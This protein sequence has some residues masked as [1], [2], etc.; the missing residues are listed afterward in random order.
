[1][2]IS[3]EKVFEEMDALL[4][5]FGT[6]VV[7]GGAVRDYL[8]SRTPKDYDI[9]ILNTA[10]IET[11]SSVKEKVKIATRDI[12]K[13]E[14][15][16]EWHKSEPFLI[17]SIAT[18]YGE[19]QIMARDIKTQEDLIDTFDWNVSRFSFGRDGFVNGEDVSNI[20]HGKDLV[21]HRIT[22]PLSTLRRGYR[23]SERFTMRLK[24]TDVKK[25]CE[26]ISKKNE[27]DNKIPEATIE[28]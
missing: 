22:H 6:V 8:M 27:E 23:F 18:P 5:P 21:L 19:V 24:Y 4:S 10:G 9:F 3:I 28:G 11:F 20:G 26:I 14:I 17:E 2:T 16:Y 12:P 1:M 15:K 13:V 25:L 7:A